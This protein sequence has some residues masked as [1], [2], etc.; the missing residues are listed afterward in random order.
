[1]R[2]YIQS[3]S[4][5]SSCICTIGICIYIHEHTHTN[6]IEQVFI[7][8]FFLPNLIQISIFILYLL[9]RMNMPSS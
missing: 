3:D 2:K 7:L 6:I 5:S 9:L 8:T 4:V 1:M